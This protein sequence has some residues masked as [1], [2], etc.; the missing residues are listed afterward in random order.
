MWQ[1]NIDE[2][3]FNTNKV[4]GRLLKFVNEAFTEDGEKKDDMVATPSKKACK[5]CEFKRTEHCKW[6]MWYDEILFN[7]NETEWCY[8]R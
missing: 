8:Q 1:R 4:N 5:W 3:L 6:G 7:R 2:I